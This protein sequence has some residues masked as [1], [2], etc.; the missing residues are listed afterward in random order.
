[1]KKYIREPFS[2]LSHL[3]GAILS[4]AALIILL[5][6]SGASHRAIIAS[7]VYGISLIILFLA[8]A[9]VHGLHCSPKLESRLEQCDHAAIYFLIAGTYTPVCLLMIR[10]PLGWSLLII[11]WIIAAIGVYMIF[12]KPG[13]SK[14]RRVATYIAMGWLF[15]FAINPIIIA[16]PNSLLM[17]LIAGGLFYS[18]GSIFFI[19]NRPTLLKEHFEGHELWHVFV[20]GG[21]VCHFIF[22]SNYIVGM[23]S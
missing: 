22:I 2:S 4:V 10:G 1:M 12:F 21:S 18:V 19:T 17:W 16:V 7:A 14:F 5:Q 3:V 23:H 20:L 9:L 13:V 6:E 8:S 11:E 15:L